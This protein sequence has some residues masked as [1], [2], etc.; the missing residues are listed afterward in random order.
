MGVLQRLKSAAALTATAG[1]LV[2]T[3]GAPA[4]AAPGEPGDD[5]LHDVQIVTTSGQ[6]GSFEQQEV[7][8][9]SGRVAISGGTEAKAESTAQNLSIVESVPRMGG[10]EP[11]YATGWTSSVRWLWSDVAPMT[12]TTYAVCAM[13]PGGYEVVSNSVT[14]AAPSQGTVATCP[15]GKV[16]LGGGSRAE[17]ESAGVSSS[18]PA[19]GSGATAA[20][21]WKVDG[22]NLHSDYGAPVT[23]TAYAVCSSPVPE[24]S[25][26]RYSG[27]GENPVGGL[28]TCPDGKI[29]IGGG[30]NGREEVGAS[31]SAS[32][33]AK[34]AETG[35]RDGWWA[36]STDS[37]SNADFELF[38]ICAKP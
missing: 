34:A 28:L 25:V 29:V 10:G 17:G 31:L 36:Q 16:T 6:I 38:V 18:Y 3:A 9:P 12:V 4:P 37:R 8:C 24:L 2:L 33:P 20:N 30:M 21:Q 15:A 22:Y 32:R 7:T 19:Y 11:G 14:S 26:G 23:T 1:T 13:L 5:G 27:S 35:R